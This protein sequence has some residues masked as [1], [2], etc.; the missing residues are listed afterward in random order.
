M[1]VWKK[2]DIHTINNMNNNNKNSAKSNNKDNSTINAL[3]KIP[4]WKEGEIYTRGMI[5]KINDDSI[6]QLQSLSHEAKIAPNKTSF[7]HH[8]LLNFTT[9]Y[10]SDALLSPMLL[11]TKLIIMINALLLAILSFYQQ[12]RFGF[13]FVAFSILIYIEMKST[14][15]SRLYDFYI[16]FI[17]KMSGS[18]LFLQ[19]SK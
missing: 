1:G 5:V 15:I 18:S 14:S 4:I 11:S 19:K 17:N 10:N 12:R 7:L 8:K 16:S 2:H 13:V 3:S 6:Y 9:H